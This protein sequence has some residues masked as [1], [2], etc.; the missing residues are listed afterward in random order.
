MAK[1]SLD[2]PIPRP[3]APAIS[4][5]PAGARRKRRP[6]GRVRDDHTV[7]GAILEPSG[8]VRAS[9]LATGLKA[10]A[11]DL[12]SGALD[13]RWIG[14]ARI[15]ERTPKHI[16]GTVNLIRVS[17]LH[18]HAAGLVQ[19]PEE[20]LDGTFAAH[21]LDPKTRRVAEALIGAQGRILNEFFAKPNA[22]PIAVAAE[23]GLSI[24]TLDDLRDYARDLEDW[25]LR[26]MSRMLRGGDID[27]RQIDYLL[28]PVAARMGELEGGKLGGFFTALVHQWILGVSFSRIPREGPQR[29]E[30]LVAVIYSRI[31][32]L[33]I[34]PG[35]LDTR[36]RYAAWRRS[37]SSR[38]SSGVRYASFSRRQ[39]WL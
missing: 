22:P 1:P 39:H 24:Q 11:V 21:F 33:C 30:D 13:E 12:A 8:I 16:Q 19:S 7:R 3:S 26:S 10:V 14:T 37:Y 15:D 31:Q 23:L 6:A 32:Y 29:V 35:F 28:S 5:Y 36:L 27:E 9:A 20:I 2:G 17:L 38:A 34:A 25:Q 4:L 18:A